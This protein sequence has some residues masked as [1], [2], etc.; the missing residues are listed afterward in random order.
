MNRCKK[1]END[2]PNEKVIRHISVQT[3]V[4]NVKNNNFS[5]QSLFNPFWKHVWA[6]HQHESTFTQSHALRFAEANHNT[7][8]K[9]ALSIE[10]PRLKS[11]A[12]SALKPL[13]KCPVSDRLVRSSALKC[14][15]A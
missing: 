8:L 11:A 5:T 10:M 13:P 9:E 12:F 15:I 3:A 6:K 4:G 7:R 14:P 1:E 2:F